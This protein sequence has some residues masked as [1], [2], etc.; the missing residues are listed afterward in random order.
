MD[1]TGLLGVMTS[2]QWSDDAKVWGNGWK[3][4][5]GRG[6]RRPGP[7]RIPGRRRGYHCVYIFIEESLERLS[8]PLPPTSLRPRPGWNTR[9]RVWCSTGGEARP[10]WTGIFGDSQRP[11]TPRHLWYNHK[12]PLSGDEG[13]KDVSPSLACVYAHVCVRTRV[14]TCVR[15]GPSVDPGPGGYSVGGNPRLGVSEHYSMWWCRW[16]LRAYIDP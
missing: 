13:R 1:G 8:V 5:S 11:P 12:F 4:P 7:N 15:T 6:C 2:S 3:G 10:G 16:H 14:C 9:R